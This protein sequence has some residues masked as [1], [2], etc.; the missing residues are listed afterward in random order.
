[1]RDENTATFSEG[2]PVDDPNPTEEPLDTLD[3]EETVDVGTEWD[4][5]EPT[6]P[7]QEVA[8]DN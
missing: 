7:T 5:V 3:G 6:E 1:M 2:S 4:P 8:N